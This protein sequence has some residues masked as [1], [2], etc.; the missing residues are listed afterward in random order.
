LSVRGAQW[1]AYALMAFTTVGLLSAASRS[2]LTVLV[3]ALLV[4]FAFAYLGRLVTRSEL[5]RSLRTLVGGGLVGLAS[6]F[7]MAFLLGQ[8]AMVRFETLLLRIVLWPLQI[9]SHSAADQSF[10]GRFNWT[11]YDGSSSTGGGVIDSAYLFLW[12]ANPLVLIV[13]VAY[14]ALS[15]FWVIRRWRCRPDV[16]ASLNLSMFT[17]IILVGF[18]GQV[19]WAFPV[20]IILSVMFGWVLRDVVPPT[21]PPRI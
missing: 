21:G 3:G 15:G 5:L 12:Y 11:P 18:I 20:W 17:F 19:Y 2:A 4:Y 13:L 8:T 16:T 7:G 10:S 9:N 6:A 1:S 14:F